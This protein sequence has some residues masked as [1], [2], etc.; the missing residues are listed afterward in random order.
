MPGLIKYIFPTAKT[1][2]REDSPEKTRKKWKP[3]RTKAGF[4]I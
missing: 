1:S 3:Y 2:T 4:L